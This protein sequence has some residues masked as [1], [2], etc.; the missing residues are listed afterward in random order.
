VREG[1]CAKVRCPEATC[2]IKNA[3]QGM[4]EQGMYQA[5]EGEAGEEDVQ[6]VLSEVE[7]VRWK[8]LRFQRAIDRDPTTVLC[9]L[10]SCQAP[11][12][13]PIA[14]VEPKKAS[15][16]IRYDAWNDLR[17]CGRCGYSFC[18]I[19]RHL[20][21]GPVTAC[22]TETSASDK[23]VWE[24][25]DLVEDSLERL[26]MERMYGRDALRVMLAQY[27]KYS[28]DKMRKDVK[29]EE[30]FAMKTYIASKTSLIWIKEN[31]TACPR[32]EVRCEK[33]GG[34]DHMQCTACEEYFCYRCGGS[35]C[36]S[37]DLP[38]CSC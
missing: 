23:L 11:V 19:C 9:P 29:A 4:E 5:D 15:N 33:N 3:A 22:F 28:E 12:L 14:T 25:L 10:Q 20:W 34:C 21:H 30:E 8:W 38:P 6:R 1:Q 2:I 26:A 36:N 35:I 17:S 37:I 7:I 31:T 13:K 24:Y 27:L 32:C 18:V 16:N